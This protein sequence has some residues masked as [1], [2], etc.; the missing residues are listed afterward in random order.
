MKE[1][2]MGLTKYLKQSIVFISLKKTI[3]LFYLPFY[4]IIYL[5]NYVYI[6]WISSPLEVGVT[7]LKKSSKINFYYYYQKKNDYFLD[8]TSF[9]YY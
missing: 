2:F 9:F 8:S 3:R 5:I 4:Y 7:T 1:M 6:N